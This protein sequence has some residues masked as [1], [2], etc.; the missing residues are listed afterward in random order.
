MVT[1]GIP[2]D[3]LFGSHLLERVSWALLLL[4]CAGIVAGQ[5]S[6][7]GQEVQRERVVVTGTYE[8]VPLEEADRSVRVL[9]ETASPRLLRW[10]AVDLLRLDS[11]VD[12]RQRAPNNIQTDL[13]IRGS[14]FG[15]T[16]VLLDGLRLNDVQTG[17][18]NMNLPLPA[19]SLDRIEVLRGS[20]STLYGADAVGGV[21][22]LIPR[23]PDEPELRL[24][25]GIGSFGTNNQGVGLSF[26]GRDWSQELTATRDFSSGFRPNRD[27]RQL[28]LSSTTRARS[29]LGN[30][31]AILG[32]ADRPFGAD[33]FYGDFNSWERTRVWFAGLR[34]QLGEQTQVA[35][36]FRRNT[37]LFVLYRDR[38]EVFTNR[39]AVESWQLSL[40]RRQSLPRNVTFYYGTELLTDS[41]ESN[42]LG[43]HS[44]GRGAVYAAFDLRAIRRFSV[45]AGVRDD[46]YSSFNHKVSPMISA[47]AWFAATVKLR[48]AITSAF[49]LPTYTDLYYQDPANKGTPDLRPERA[50]TYEAGLDWNL[51]SRMRANLT[52]FQRRERDGIDYV[53]RSPA[54]V[55][56][57][58]N[59]QQLVFTGVESSV[60]FEPRR[61]HRMEVSYT[62]LRGAQDR[63][64]G[65]LSKYV[66]NYPLR[67]VVLSWNAE[68]GRGLLVRSRVGSM[69]R[70]QRDPYALWDLFLGHAGTRFRPYLHF[71]NLTATTYEEIPGVVMPGRALVV[72]IE[73][74]LRGR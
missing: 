74:Y 71:N 11:S 60:I 25:T 62:G 34:Q 46:V 21:V 61:K 65:L 5:E 36:A 10:T 26:V 24:R 7:K 19:D 8:P 73:V 13:S 54:D 37:D 53:R 28:S 63:L 67:N 3:H 52:V 50:W 9:D 29:R 64:S 27:Y 38:P 2:L 70:Y 55:W 33:R 47:A 18:H 1:F 35:L 15:Q 40:R 32:H 51:S 66:F 14:T 31:S 44:R 39:H 30:T 20:G 58:T 49:R 48:A 68:V 6:G 17:H 56:R 42:N 16:L 23:T 41:I 59:F 4:G 57:A 22:N 43:L 12:V 45:T 72:G 69:R